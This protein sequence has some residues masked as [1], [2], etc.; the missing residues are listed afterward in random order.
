[1]I[2]YPYEGYDRGE[3]TVF[4]YSFSVYEKFRRYDRSNFAIMNVPALSIEN[5]NK[6]FLRGN[7]S[8]VALKDVTF[9]VEQGEFFGLLGPNG[10]GKSTL[11][12]ILAGL[13]KPNSG[14]VA[15]LQ[16]DS[17][18]QWR[19]FHM[20]VGIVPQE[21][22]FDPHFTVKETLWLQSGYY[23]LRHND[24]WL[25]LLL[26]KL[27]LADKKNASVFSLSGGMKRRVLIAQALVHKPPVIILDEPTA[28]VDIELRHRL[29]EF[30]LELNSQG[31]T[32]ILTTHYLE[33]AERLCSRVALLN[34]GRLVALDKTQNLLRQ[35]SKERIKFAL[36]ENTDV[37]GFPFELKPLPNNFYSVENQSA[38]TLRILLDYMHQHNLQPEGLEL[39][40]ANLEEVF[41]RLTK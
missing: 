12:N 13:V 7:G 28:G 27:E 4:V 16:N 30:M 35:F 40:K 8:T 11:I 17:K 36:P 6:T 2:Y 26:E 21:I 19:Q 41:L 20:S 24:E 34:K 32:L 23:G 18:K 3:S 37:S 5:L 1:M 25:N 22:T 33:E 39:G 31:H 10:A 14:S 9:R 38:D 29:W 15:I